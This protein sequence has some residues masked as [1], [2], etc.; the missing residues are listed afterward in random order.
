[1]G[2]D[3]FGNSTFFGFWHDIGRSWATRSGVL[4]H[5]G[6]LTP[7]PNVMPGE[8]GVATGDDDKGKLMA[9]G[10]VAGCHDIATYSIR[11]PLLA[12]IQFM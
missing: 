5:G 4:D 6:V 12:Y 1:M 10:K 2:I 7:A 9:I 11:A 3:K 8:V